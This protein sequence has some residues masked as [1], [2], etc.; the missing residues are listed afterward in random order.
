MQAAEPGAGAAS[1]AAADPAAV[2]AFWRQAGPKR[3]FRKDEVFDAQFRERFADAHEAA[4]QHRLDAWMGSADACLA[5]LILLDQYPRNAF[6]GSARMFASDPQA[7][8][9]AAI[10]LQRGFDQA[11]AAD[12]RQFFYLPLMHSESLDDQRRSLALCRA[13]GADNLKYAQIHLDV[14][15]RF[16]R[17]PHRNA[18]LGRDTTAQEQAFLDSGGFAG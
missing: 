12:L 8:E 1:D 6:R 7:R 3:W 13:L 14:I 10:A 16:G 5:L 17:F 18:L 4:V 11:V 9:V 2:V 15:E